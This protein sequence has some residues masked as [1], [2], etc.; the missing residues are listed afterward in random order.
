MS[1]SCSHRLAEETPFN[2][3]AIGKMIAPFDRLSER[4][5]HALHYAG[6][7]Q[8]PC[9]AHSLPSPDPVQLAVTEHPAEYKT[10]GRCSGWTYRLNW[11]EGR[12]TSFVNI[13][14]PAMER[15]GSSMRWLRVADARRR[16]CTAE[17]AGGRV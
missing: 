1:V 7:M 16:L 9:Q 5:K 4:G 10:L 11:L 3:H 17:C 2:H 6:V 14:A 15:F 12:N 13:T 8:V